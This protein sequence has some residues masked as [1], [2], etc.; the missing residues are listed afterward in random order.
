MTEF[1]QFIEKYWDVISFVVREKH[2]IVQFPELILKNNAR[3]F[4]VPSPL[5]TVREHVSEIRKDPVKYILP[6]INRTFHLSMERHI[7]L[8]GGI[9]WD[10]TQ[11]AAVMKCMLKGQGVS[12]GD[13]Q[14]HVVSATTTT[15]KMI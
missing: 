5:G 3:Y 1:E 11:V 12:A 13:S 9:D 2:L 7:T 15:T 4:R 14:A 8:M 6:V 10:M